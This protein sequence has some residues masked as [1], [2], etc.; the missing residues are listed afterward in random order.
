MG[1]IVL[2]ER[3]STRPISH[4]EAVALPPQSANSP[5]RLELRAKQLKEHSE[6][7][8]QR[9]RRERRSR[10]AVCEAPRGFSLSFSAGPELSTSSCGEDVDNTAEVCQAEPEIVQVDECPENPPPADLGASYGESEVSNY[11]ANLPS[12]NPFAALYGTSA[13]ASVIQTATTIRN[14]FGAA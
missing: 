4:V 7:L 3:A 1:D 8:R 12:R 2:K 11:L 10:D 13:S 6:Q 14:Y 9:V 5:T